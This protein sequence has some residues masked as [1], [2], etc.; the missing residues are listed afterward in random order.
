LRR[1]G[2]SQAARRNKI[3]GTTLKKA[4]VGE[5]R[6]AGRAVLRIGAGDRCRI[7]SLAKNAFARLAFFDLGDHRRFPAVIFT[8]RAR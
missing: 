8:R 1:A 7:E 2:R 6:E 5:H 4:F 3:L